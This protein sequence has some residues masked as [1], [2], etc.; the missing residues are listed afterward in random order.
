MRQY[1]FILAGLIWTVS[2]G[3]WPSATEAAGPWKA[4]IV[5]AETG[6][7]LEGVVVL[8]YWIKYARTV[9]GKA[10][11]QFYDAEEVVTR[12]DGNFVIQERS[13]WTLNPFRT[14]SSADF[15]M[16]KPGYGEWRFRNADLWLKRNLPE[17][18]EALRKVYQSRGEK[19]LALRFQGEMSKLFREGS[20]KMDEVVIELPPLKRWEERRG[21]FGR[22]G[23]PTLVPLER[24]KRLEEAV[25]AER[26]YLGYRN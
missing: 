22:V 21:F 19:Y 24:T 4:Q 11:A 6:K 12:P 10:D 13:I 26:A 8:A 15:V 25:N 23:T 9:A 5:D 20:E 2:C 7:P 3:V 16:F 17:R 18:Y 14:I 1:L